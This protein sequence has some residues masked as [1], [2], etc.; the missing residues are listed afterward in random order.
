M[1]TIKCKTLFDIT[2]TGVRSY[3]KESR[4]PFQDQAGH[5]IKDMPSWTRSRNQQRNWETINQIIS[6]RTLPED[7]TAPVKDRMIWQFEFSVPDLSSIGDS[8]DPVKLL[9]NDADGVPMILGLDEK[10]NTIPYIV[11]HGNQSNIWFE[12]I[13]LNIEED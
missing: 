8:T 12:L 9:K 6:L 2:A 3:F 7:I 1:V 10:E 11:S 13:K 4:I 5:F